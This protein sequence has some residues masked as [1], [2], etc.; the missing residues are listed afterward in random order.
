M[1]RLDASRKPVRTDAARP[2][3]IL[4][5]AP[6][7]DE[8]L[9]TLL[10]PRRWW[11][12]K[13]IVGSSTVAIVSTVLVITIVSLI[14]INST[15]WAAFQ[16]A[17]LSPEHFILSFPKVWDGFLLNVVL[18]LLIEPI[19]LVVGLVLALMRNLSSPVFFPLR[20]FA[21]A[22]IDLFRGLPAILVILM[23][24][25]GMPALRI[26]GLSTSPLFWGAVACV[27]TSSAY[28][29]ENYRAG[30]ESVHPSQRSAA[31]ALG[32]GHWQ[33]MRF[34]VLPQAVR[35]VV[36]PL[37]SG[38]I[39][40]QKETALI[41]V[42]GPMEASRAAQAYSATTFNFTSYLVAALLFLAITIP[43]TRFTDYLLRRSAIRRSIGG[44]V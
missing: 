41:S 18:F 29:A 2:A 27:L 14:A 19:V 15:G 1:T 32:L 6:L 7:A 37:L 38:F 26:E 13:D 31:R 21:I 16:A 22:Y 8:E 44:A 10:K 43:L 33:T 24:G 20:V 28:A 11:R 17:F 5:A 23:L 30:I 36:P 34:V 42:I 12:R 4:P 40:L 3:A 9:R 35:R 39:A 25:M